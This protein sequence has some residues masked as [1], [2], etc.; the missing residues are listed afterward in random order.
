MVKQI[1]FQP[2]AF[3]I[4]ILIGL[5]MIGYTIY[6]TNSAKNENKQN[7]IN[8]TVPKNKEVRN[9]PLAYPSEV[10]ERVHPARERDEYLRSMHPR[11]ADLPINIPTQGYDDGLY[12]RIGVLLH[13]TNENYRLPLWGKRQYPSSHYY[14]YYVVDHTVHEN[15][16]ELDVTNELFDGDKVRVPGYPGN[17]QVY[18]YHDDQPRYHHN[19]IGSRGGPIPFRSQYGLGF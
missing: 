7:F 17:F 6:Y 10:S 9:Y 3:L 2:T 8:I 1:C 15:K 13:D 5:S 11:F 18:L 14:D 16:V 19:V 12:M 4:F